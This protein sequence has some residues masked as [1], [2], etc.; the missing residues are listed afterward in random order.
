MWLRLA[1]LLGISL[2]IVIS[3]DSLIHARRAAVRASL[4]QLNDVQ[5]P[6]GDVIVTV[7]LYRCRGLVFRGR[8]EIKFKLFRASAS[9]ASDP[10]AFL[11]FPDE[12]FRDHDMRVD[13]DGYIVTMQSNNPVEIR[14]EANEILLNMYEYE[15]DN[16]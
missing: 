2:V 16:R 6:T 3:Y 14:R 1:T 5:L 10:T 13:R 8:C 7:I 11:E 9:G 4:E 15:A 12:V